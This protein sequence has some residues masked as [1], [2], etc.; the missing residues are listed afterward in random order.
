MQSADWAASAK[1]SKHRS[2]IIASEM[3][4]AFDADKIVLMH[5]HNVASSFNARISNRTSHAEPVCIAMLVR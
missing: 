4:D 1:A 3:R 5:A 2:K